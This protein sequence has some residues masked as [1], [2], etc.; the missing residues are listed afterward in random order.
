MAQLWHPA[1][2]TAGLSGS[3][4]LCPVLG[5][6]EP[7]L[8]LNFTSATVTLSLLGAQSKAGH[9]HATGTAGRGQSWDSGGDLS[10]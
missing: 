5:K 1:Q 4:S 6:V 3:S 9:R 2:A 7:K 10:V 8:L